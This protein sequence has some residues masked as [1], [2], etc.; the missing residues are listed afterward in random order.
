[1]KNKHLLSYKLL[2]QLTIWFPLEELLWVWCCVRS[3]VYCDQPSLEL[4]NKASVLKNEKIM[5]DKSK[6]GK[7]MDN[8]KTKK[9]SRKTM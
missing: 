4:T 2:L 7:K 1:M 9:K 5:K 3:V 6:A 8:K